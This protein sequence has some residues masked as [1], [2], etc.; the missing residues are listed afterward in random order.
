MNAIPRHDAAWFNERSRG[1]LPGQLGITIDEVAQGSLRAHLDVQPHHLAPNGYLHA[2]SVIALADTSAGYACIAHLPETAENFTTL[3][4]K[5]SFL[6]TVR[7]GRIE[8]EARAVHLG[9][10]TQVWE[11]RVSNPA[12]GR[13]LATFQCTQLLLARRDAAQRSPGG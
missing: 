3:E 5:A 10:S 4:L 2:A 9:R 13:L 7:E 8:C 1:H 12:N 11:A 6:G